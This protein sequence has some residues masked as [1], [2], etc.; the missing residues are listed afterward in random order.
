MDERHVWARTDA[1][2][3]FA[4]RG[5][6]LLGRAVA[7]HAAVELV[8][9]HQDVGVEPLLLKGPVL[10]RLLYRPG[11]HRGYYDIDVLVAPECLD[12]TRA[13]LRGLGYEDRTARSGV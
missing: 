13:T 3:D 2:K 1:L 6:N 5:E 11:E 9:R 8:A 7:E 12:R 4:A 10:A